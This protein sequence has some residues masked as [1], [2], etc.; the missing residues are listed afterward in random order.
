MIFFEDVLDIGVI[1]FK[2]CVDNSDFVIDYFHQLLRVLTQVDAL[3]RIGVIVPAEV[4]QVFFWS[5]ENQ[6]EEEVEDCIDLITLVCICERLQF[7]H[8]EVIQTNLLW[9]LE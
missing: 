5:G 9:I 6:L 1:H 7:N 4:L 2:S 8:F 3:T